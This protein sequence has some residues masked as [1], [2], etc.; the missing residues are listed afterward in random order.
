MLREDGYPCLFYGDYYGLRGDHP[1]ECQKDMINQL[2]DIR[3]QFAW[4]KQTDYMATENLIGW[5][6]HGDEEHPKKLA[7]LIS[8]A[9]SNTLE[10]N[11]G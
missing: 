3:K 7:I 2:V 1:I 11:V 8:T 5:V 4:G 6:R 10:M 9:D